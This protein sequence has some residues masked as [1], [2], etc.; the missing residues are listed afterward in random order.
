MAS[1]SPHRFLWMFLVVLFAFGQVLN[2]NPSTTQQTAAKQTAIPKNP[3]IPKTEIPP[4]D[5]G[6]GVRL[7]FSLSHRESPPGTTFFSTHLVFP[8]DHEISDRQLRQIAIEGYREMEAM[9]S[10]YQ[11]QKPVPGLIKRQKPSVLTIIAIDRDVHGRKTREIIM[12]SSHR[13][14]GSVLGLDSPVSGQLDTCRADSSTDHK[15][16]RRCGEVGA[17]HLYSTTGRDPTA[18]GREVRVGAITTRGKQQ[19]EYVLIPPCGSDTG[20]CACIKSLPCIP[21]YRYHQHLQNKH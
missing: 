4:D 15:N 13:L 17:L 6:Y 1:Y 7:D 14:G 10:W 21:C 5:T 9:F 19:V 12:A 20:V 2:A 11:A 16:D 3:S 8:N 18:L